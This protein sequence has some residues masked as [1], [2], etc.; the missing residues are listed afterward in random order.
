M[1]EQLLKLKC[2]YFGCKKHPGHYLWAPASMAIYGP[3]HR[4]IAKFDGLLCPE[5]CKIQGKALLHHFDGFTILAFWDSSVDKRP[6]SNS[7]FIIPGIRD[8]DDSLTIVEDNFPDVFSRFVFEVEPY[9][10]P[11]PSGIGIPCEP[12]VRAAHEWVNICMK[13]YHDSREVPDDLVRLC[14]ALAGID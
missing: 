8:F 12:L 3:W 1:L 7:M 6:E 10:T 13:D 14:K 9:I 4:R 11:P 2:L 5:F